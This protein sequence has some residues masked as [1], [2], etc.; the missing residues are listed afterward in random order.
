MEARASIRGLNDALKAIQ[1]AFPNDV[2]K[3]SRMINGAMGGAAR[4]TFLQTAKL[5]ALKGDGSGALS[6]SLAVRAQKASR[7]KGKAGGMQVVPVRSSRKALALYINYYY[8]SQGKIPPASIL[9]HGITHGHLVE[10]GHAIRGGGHV[11]ADSFLWAST[12][13]MR[14]YTSLFAGGMKKRIAAAVKRAAKRRAKK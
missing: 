6:E 3:Q 14:E 13:R 9:T 10:F 12:V 7:R 5:L 11:P 2:K 1:A 4:K 8:T